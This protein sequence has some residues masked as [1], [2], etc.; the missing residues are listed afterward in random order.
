MGSV[1]LSLMILLA[2]TSRARAE[3]S[4]ADRALAEALFRDAN[5]LIAE[6]KIAE[7]CPK[8]VESYRLDPKLG[9]LLY[10]ATCHEQE[11]KTAT[12]W[13]EFNEAATMAARAR[14][15]ARE[16]MAR[17]R[18]DAL[19][20][21][22]TRVVIE[23]VAP[24]AGA[25]IELDGREL[26]AIALGASIPLDPGEHTIRASAPGKVTW[27]K[28]FTLAAPGTV[29]LE[30]PSLEDEPRAAPLP[31]PREVRASVPRSSPTL[32][33]VLGGVGVLAAGFG[34]YMG[35]LMLQRSSHADQGCVGRYCTREALDTF[36]E[37]RTQ[38]TIATIAL[39]AGVL[40]VASAT[41]VFL[42]NEPPSASAA[43][44]MTGSFVW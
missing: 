11:G 36:D 35:A 3:S 34:A 33:W 10:V 44:T 31:P 20:P 26:S 7:A 27:S 17:R 19:E 28:T 13:I 29:T 25:E 24:A 15:P 43:R 32:G 12:A 14:Q 18:A 2:S 6:G 4:A 30:V 9:A 16:K 40:L 41:Y 42:T 22:L 5:A 1:L 38:G 8:L 23:P 39:G 37:A 21:K